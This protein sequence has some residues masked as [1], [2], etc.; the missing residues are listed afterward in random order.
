MSPFTSAHYVMSDTP[1][2]S[3]L[4]NCVTQHLGNT[5]RYHIRSFSQKISYRISHDPEHPHGHSPLSIPSSL[6]SFTP[7]DEIDDVS[8]PLPPHPPPTTLNQLGAVI[9]QRQDLET[10]RAHFQNSALAHRQ[11]SCYNA[12][13]VTQHAFYDSATRQ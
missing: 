12:I 10:H 6:L 4:K 8:R 7:T 9:C 1:R 13:N 5:P 11:E 3:P 2:L